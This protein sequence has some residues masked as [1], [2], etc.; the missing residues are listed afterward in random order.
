[1]VVVLVVVVVKVGVAGGSGGGG[2]EGGWF[3][4]QVVSNFAMENPRR[5]EISFEG[6]M[7]HSA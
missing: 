6:K 5:N 7:S 1:M 4:G 3:S 2:S